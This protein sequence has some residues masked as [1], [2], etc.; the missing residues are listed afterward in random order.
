MKSVRLPVF[1]ILSLCLTGCFLRPDITK[2]YVIDAS[3]PYTVIYAFKRN[4][5]QLRVRVYGNIKGT[6]RIRWGFGGKDGGYSQISDCNFILSDAE[7]VP[8][9]TDSVNFTYKPSG[10]S[11]KGY[12]QFLIYSPEDVQSGDSIRIEVREFGFSWL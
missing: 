6:C 7:S 9:Y 5:S 8:K 4:K 2:E 1:I 10:P 12:T 11:M 3:K